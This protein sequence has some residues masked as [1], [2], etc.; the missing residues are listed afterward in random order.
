MFRGTHDILLS[1]YLVQLIN[2]SGHVIIL[3]WSRYRSFGTSV[4]PKPHFL[5]HRERVNGLIPVTH[6]CRASLQKLLPILPIQDVV[7]ET[8]SLYHLYRAWLLNFSDFSSPNRAFLLKLLP[9]SRFY[10]GVLPGTACLHRGGVV[11]ETYLFLRQRRPIYDVLRRI[12]YLDLPTR[13]VVSELPEILQGPEKKLPIYSEPS[14]TPIW[15]SYEEPDFE[16]Y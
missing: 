14:V 13:D 11:S 2:D 4:T 8:Q 1:G 6:Q 12:H 9:S 5:G 15:R 7:S 3:A 16:L 10:R